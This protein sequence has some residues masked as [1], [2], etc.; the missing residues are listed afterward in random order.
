MDSVTGEG[1]EEV[2]WESGEKYQGDGSIVEVVVLF[3]GGDERA[4]G[5]VVEAEIEESLEG[6]STIVLKA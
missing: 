2:A 6:W 1:C 3:E 4:V 5:G